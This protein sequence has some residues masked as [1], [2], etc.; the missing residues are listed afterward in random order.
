MLLNTTRCTFMCNST[1][2]NAKSDKNN[3]DTE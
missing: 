2:E 1:E 3:S